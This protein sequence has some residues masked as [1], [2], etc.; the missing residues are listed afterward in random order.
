MHIGHDEV[1]DGQA[2][3]ACEHLNDDTPD[4]FHRRIE[5][6]AVEVIIGLRVVL[7]LHESREFFQRLLL[8]FPGRILKGKEFNLLVAH[9]SPLISKKKAKIDFHMSLAEASDC[10]PS[11][12]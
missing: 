9:V 11:S 6:L 8:N 10:L 5:L 7:P 2:L 3:Q 1:G 4:G 12:S